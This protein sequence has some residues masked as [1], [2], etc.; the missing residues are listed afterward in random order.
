MTLQSR[1]HWLPNS[2]GA[3]PEEVLTKPAQERITFPG[4]PSVASPVVT[5]NNGVLM[6]KSMPIY[7]DA[8]SRGLE[9]LERPQLWPSRDVNEEMAPWDSKY[10][11]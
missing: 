1:S 7:D 2:S 9:L 5:S 10:R 3:L 11:D 8:K 4:I 6:G